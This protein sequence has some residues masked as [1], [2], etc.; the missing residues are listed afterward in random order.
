VLVRLVV[1]VFGGSYDL[2]VG[3]GQEADGASR[4]RNMTRVGPKASS[5]VSAYGWR[6]VGFQV[7][8]GASVTMPESLQV[9]LGR[10]ASSRSRPAQGSS[11]SPMTGL[12]M[13]STTNLSWGRLWDGLDRGGQVRGLGE[14]VVGQA[15]VGDGGEPRVGRRAGGASRHRV[16]RGPG[17]GSPSGTSRP[18]GTADRRGPRQQSGAVRSTQPTTPRDEVR[19]W[20]QA[21]GTRRSRR[22]TRSSGP[23]R[24]T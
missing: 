16:R 10:A 4:S 22:P 21:P 12:E 1:R 15:G 18:G 5:T 6:S 7:D 3:R 14:Q 13:W 23:A 2:V 19:C 17:A 8:Q 20:R 24:S 11:G 9:T